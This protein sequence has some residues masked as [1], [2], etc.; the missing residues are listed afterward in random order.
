M[1]TPAQANAVASHFGMNPAKMYGKPVRVGL[2]QKYSQLKINK[3]KGKTQ[4]KE[5]QQGP[6]QQNEKG[7][8]WQNKQGPKRQN[9]QAPAEPKRQDANEGQK[10]QGSNEEEKAQAPNEQP[11][12]GAGRVVQICNLPKSGYS[13]QKVLSLAKNYGKVT[14]YILMRHQAFVEMERAEDAQAMID[15]CAKT[16]LKLQGRVLYVILSQKYKSLVLKI[17]PRA[18][19]EERKRI[20]SKGNKRGAK[21]QKMNAGMAA[22]VTTEDTE[23]EEPELNDS[24]EPGEKEEAAATTLETS[25]LGI[26]DGEVDQN[27]E[28]AHRNEGFVIDEIRN[29]AGKEIQR[30]E[31]METDQPATESANTERELE[32]NQPTVPTGVDCIIPKAGFYCK[33]CSLFYQDED[34]AKVTHCNTLAHHQNVKK[35]LSKPNVKEETE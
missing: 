27:H 17:P 25:D 16:P 11:K 15:A 6:K 2:S 34:M 29:E 12:E 21:K 8:K 3:Q 1:A 10:P 23:D 22:M 13:Q 35:M 18:Q 7:A 4:P 5:P 14:K 20:R 9:K 19:R 24:C 28:T 31:D 33:A 30:T 26:P 32:P